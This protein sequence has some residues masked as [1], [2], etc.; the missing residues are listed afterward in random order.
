MGLHLVAYGGRND[1]LFHGGIGE[2][3]FFPDQ[4]TVGE[5]EYQFDRV[6]QQS[7]CASVPENQQM[8]CLRSKND[9]ALQALNNGQAFPGRTASPP[10]LFYWTPCIDGDL[11]PDLPYTLFQTGK[12][13]HAPV[14]FGT[15]TNEGSMFAFDAHNPAEMVNFFYNNYPKLTANDTDTIVAMYPQMPPLPQH[16]AWFPSTSMAYGEATFICPTVNILNAVQAGGGGSGAPGIYSYRY[17]VQDDQL[18]ADGLG[19]VHTF[20]AA[21]VFGPDNVGGIALPSYYTYN[22]PIIPVV[23]NYVISFVRTLDPNPYRAPG[24]PV[25]EP[26]ASGQGMGRLLFETNNSRM[27]VTPQDQLARCEFWLGVGMAT[28]EQ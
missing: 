20:E 17:N 18:N 22:A 2:S 23:M 7:G 11:F 12:F 6:M 16:Q 28:A 25:W 5:L 24:A 19:V 8:S 13:V 3:L 10:P 21:A 1:S 9:T 27:E 26:W 15:A 4:P 14:L